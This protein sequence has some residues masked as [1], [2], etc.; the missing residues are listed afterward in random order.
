MSATYVF[1]AGIGNSGPDHWQRRWHQRLGGVWVEHASWDKPVLGAWL[2]DLDDVLE[3][4]EGPKVIIAHSLGCLLVT[5]WADGHAGSGIASGIGSG[6]D[7]VFLVAL[8]DALGP[9]F[10]AEAEGFGPQRRRRLSFPAVLVASE[11]DPYCSL[12]HA[13]A[14]AGEL[15]ASLVNVGPQGHINAASGLGDWHD[16]WS[17]FS[18]RFTR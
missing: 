14:V 15:G 5:E 10:P 11:D 12:R 8:P 13:T 9:S 7:G 2:K 1:L 3:A 18:A 17:I 4:V 6:I 16:G